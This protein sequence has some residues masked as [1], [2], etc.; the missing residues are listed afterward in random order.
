MSDRA[1]GQGG[2]D[3]WIAT[4]AADGNFDPPS[5]LLSPVNTGADEQG[6]V[7]SADELQ[8]FI[9]RDSAL[10][11]TSR[12]SAS[13]PFSAPTAITEL[14]A[15]STPLS[16]TWVTPDGCTLYSPMAPYPT[17]GT[18]SPYVATRGK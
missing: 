12:A 4:S 6:I 17:A 3:I 1:G 9:T 5:D 14:N 10:Y 16:A 8:A 7:L 18:T 2:R 13:A 15:F 11:Y